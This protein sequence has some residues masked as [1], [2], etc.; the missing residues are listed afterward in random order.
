MLLSN[1]KIQY[2]RYWLMKKFRKF[3]LSS[4]L[5]KIQILSFIIKKKSTIWASAWKKNL[6]SW[7]M[8]K[9]RFVWTP[10]CLQSSE[11][12]HLP[13]CTIQILGFW[14]S[15]LMTKFNFWGFDWCPNSEYDDMPNDKIQTLCFYDSMILILKILSFST[16]D[17]LQS[18]DSDLL[19][20]NKIQ[21]LKM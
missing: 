16:S 15:W 8:K 4:W 9:G 12:E 14:L 17:W 19:T 11:F 7:Q 20:D 21:I 5:L 1:D 13:G 10:V 3:W 2:L 6:N 18:L